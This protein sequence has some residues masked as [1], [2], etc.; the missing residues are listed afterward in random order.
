MRFPKMLLPLI[1]F[2]LLAGCMSPKEASDALVGHF[3]W[4]GEEDGFA[5]CMYF[6]EENQLIVLGALPTMAAAEGNTEEIRDDALEV[7]RSEGFWEIG[8]GL[9]LDFKLLPVLRHTAIDGKVVKTFDYR[10]T[11]ADTINF[12]RSKY[13]IRS[14]SDSELVYRSADEETWFRSYRADS[15]PE[16]FNPRA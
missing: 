8:K 4:G 7:K 14:I 9:R 1:T 5:W 15:C 10:D 6:G 11:G 16:R 13:L 12:N 2:Q 3:W